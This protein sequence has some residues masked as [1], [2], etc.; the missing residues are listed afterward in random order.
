MTS[1]PVAAFDPI[2]WVHHS[3]IDRAIVMWQTYNNTINPLAW[4]YPTG[5]N[6]QTLTGQQFSSLSNNDKTLGSGFFKVTQHLTVDPVAFF[7]PDSP[8]D[9][10]PQYTPDNIIPLNTY[11]VTYTNLQQ[12]ITS[13]TQNAP[14]V[15][16]TAFTVPK[17]NLNSITKA[18]SLS[19]VDPVDDGEEKCKS[20]GNWAVDILHFNRRSLNG[21]CSLDLVVNNKIRESHAFFVR[22]GRE[23]DCNNCLVNMFENIEF[24]VDDFDPHAD[25]WDLQIQYINEDKPICL[26]DID[27]GADI[28]L[29]KLEQVLFHQSLLF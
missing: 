20:K 8:Y 11:I 23:S 5:L 21:P 15:L 22:D 6:V 19:F 26:K 28:N 29:S 1:P 13:W 10:F 9:N 16:N 4:Q 14:I 7:E 17:V 25:E 3:N 24:K 27:C 12:A 2:F 18:N